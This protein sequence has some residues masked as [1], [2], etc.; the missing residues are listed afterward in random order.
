MTTTKIFDRELLSAARDLKY[1]NR[2]AWQRFLSDHPELAAEAGKPKLSEEA[3][4]VGSPEGYEPYQ[5]WRYADRGRHRRGKGAGSGDTDT[6]DFDHLQTAATVS[7]QMFATAEGPA[8]SLL[9]LHIAVGADGYSITPTL[10]APQHQ[11]EVCRLC[12][13]PLDL[14]RDDDGLVDRDSGGQPAYCV[15][16]KCKQTVK[17]ARERAK[18]TIDNPNPARKRKRSTDWETSR[19]DR[20]ARRFGTGGTPGAPQTARIY[21]EGWDRVTTFWRFPTTRTACLGVTQGEDGAW[22]VTDTS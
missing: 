3:Y 13:K 8:G 17:N 18:Y 12:G 1:E 20:I 16:T 14:P 7:Q 9:D 5:C 4:T 10:I 11:L 19:A 22:R 6:D 2:A 15:G 21:V